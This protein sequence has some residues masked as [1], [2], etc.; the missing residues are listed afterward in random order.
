[1]G[2]VV[3]KTVPIV[4]PPP[5]RTA[6]P[7][8]APSIGGVMLSGDAG[9]EGIDAGQITSAVIGFSSFNLIVHGENVAVADIDISKFLTVLWA[10]YFSDE[11]PG[12]SI[13]PIYIGCDQMAVRHIGAVRNTDLGMTLLDADYYMKKCAVG[14]IDPGIPGFRSVDQI[15]ESMGIHD[16][17]A[18]RRFWFVPERMRFRRAGNAILFESGSMTLKTEYMFLDGTAGTAEPADL[19]FA[20][21]WTENYERFAEVNP[22]YREMFEYAKAVGLAKYLKQNMVPLQSFLLEHRDMLLTCEMPGTVPALT[23]PS[24]WLP[25]VEIYGGV[26]LC[27]DIASHSRDGYDPVIYEIAWQAMERGLLWAAGGGGASSGEGHTTLADE[28]ASMEIQGK[29]YTIIP[30]TSFSNRGD[31]AIGGLTTDLTVWSE[32]KPGPALIRQSSANR[33]EAGEF[34]DG[35][36]IYVP[37]RIETPSPTRIP[38][39]NAI[40]PE[41]VELVDPASGD[42]HRLRFD[43]SRLGIAAYVPREPHTH[44]LIG[45]LV[46]SDGSF[47]L[48]ERSGYE[49][50][51]D[52]SGRCTD[53]VFSDG[54][55]M[56]YAYVGERIVRISGPSDEWIDL[57]YAEGRLRRAMAGKK[58]LAYE[59]DGEGRLIGTRAI[60]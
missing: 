56:H 24:R 11:D 52:P 50:A 42:R 6:V 10:V 55:G 20:D 17:G 57:Y 23:R 49:F 32:G 39:L 60:G 9:I 12:I 40:I 29:P 59:Y 54:Y 38:Y 34:G 37:Y 48:I 47:R 28:G 31:G 4:P 15:H 14:T 25:D 45:L 5:L 44:H 2:G 16:L 41:E 46:L 18:M 22:V 43:E 30:A 8:T 33:T 35:T 36:G 3:S 19:A 53:L 51:F 1:M 58:G 27:V 26:D 21:F 13:D 7:Q